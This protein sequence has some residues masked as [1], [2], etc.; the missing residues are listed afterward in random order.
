M[1][2]K[3][4]IV[5][6]KPNNQKKLYQD[7]SS[8]FTGIEPPL[9]LAVTAAFLREQGFEVV[10]IDAEADNLNVEE[11]V[12]RAVDYDPVIA[13][14]VVSGTNPSASTMNMP[15]AGQALKQFKD[16]APKIA[17]VITGLHPSAL[18]EQTTK[19]ESV[20]FVFEGEGL[21]TFVELL[22]ALKGGKKKTDDLQINGLWYKRGDKI[23]SNPRPANIQDLSSLPMPAWDLL[24]MDKYR[25]HNWHAFDDVK[26]RQP[27]AVIYTSLGCPFICSFCCINVT[28]GASGIRYRPPQ[29][30]VEEID[31]LVKTYGV[32][33]I[34][35]ID[36]MFALKPSHVNELCDRIIELGYDLNFWVYGRIDTVKPDMLVKMKQAGMN[37]IAY[38]IEA[39][40]KKVREGVSKGRFDEEKIREVIQMTKDAGIYIVGNYIFGL[41]EDDL[42]TMK[43]T[44]DLAKELNCE[45]SNFYCAMAYPGSQLYTDAVEKGWPL[46]KEWS[47]YSQFGKDAL[48]LPTNHLRSGQV[49]KFRDEAFDDYY[50]DPK[51]LNMVEETFGAKTYEHIKKMCEIKL[52]RNNY[53][54]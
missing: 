23:I 11:T 21:T 54:K 26:K 49:L 12:A 27:Y 13:A 37:W 14:I 46:P 53:D 1:S 20:D 32:R 9:W 39:G 35:I 34:K 5:L 15:S 29:K 36:E 38:G 52:K 42:E 50:Q 30:V 8:D 41:P 51:Y 16:V 6:I 31:Y 33:H 4:D 24:P 45:Y 48:P 43:E 44:L 19:E 17:T 2:Q 7:L 3:T 40:S 25:A 28:F 22:N 10:A 47:G 18:P